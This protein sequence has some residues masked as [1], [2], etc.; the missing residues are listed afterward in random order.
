MVLYISYEEVRAVRL[1]ARSVLGDETHG[2]CA[3]AAPPPAARAE[4]SALQER[5]V[6]DLDVDTLAEQ[7]ALVLALS[8]IVECLR[9]EMETLV[10][11]THPAHEGAVAAYFDYAHSLSVLQRLQDMGS[12]MEAMIEVL[13]GSPVD[14]VAEASFHFPD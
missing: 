6:G 13:T 11:E 5:L 2:M 12:E 4:I 3:V 7:R 10:G 8:S 14:G 1:G 9:V